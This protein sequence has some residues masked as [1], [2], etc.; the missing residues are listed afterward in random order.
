MPSNHLDHI[1]TVQAAA[2]DTEAA[3]TVEKF[4]EVAN[5]TATMQD[6]WKVMSTDSKIFGRDSAKDHAYFKAVDEGLKKSGLLPEITV[7]YAQWHKDD[8]CNDDN[9]IG[10]KDIREWRYQRQMQNGRVTEVEGDL[11]NNLS[12][13]YKDMYNKGRKLTDDYDSKGITD[14]M[15]AKLDTNYAESRHKSEADQE[16]KAEDRALAAGLVKN[17][18]ANGGAL[19]NKLAQANGGRYIDQASIDSACDYDLSNRQRAKVPG[20]KWHSYLDYNDHVWLCKLQ[21]NM[22]RISGN[23]HVTLND[24]QEFAKKQGS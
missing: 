12:T 14:A 19:Y 9:Q 15:L 24:L 20:Q 4:R 8:L 10:R 16:K 1:V 18:S 6:A 11:I 13:S 7:K 21:D 17:F 5:G 23:G 3:K 2:P 22:T